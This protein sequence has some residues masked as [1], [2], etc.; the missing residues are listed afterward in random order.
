MKTKIMSLTLALGDHLELRA[1][2]HN[3]TRVD[4]ATT[5]LTLALADHLELCAGKHNHT[6]VDSG[7]GDD[8]QLHEVFE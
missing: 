2:K 3:H 8:T 1:G 5:T 4:T 7:C 6:R